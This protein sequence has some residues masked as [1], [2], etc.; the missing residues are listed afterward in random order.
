MAMS[1]VASISVSLYLN[2]Q[3]IKSIKRMRGKAMRRKEIPGESQ[4]IEQ[5]TVTIA[6]AKSPPD[7]IVKIDVT[8]SKP[9]SR[10]WVL[11]EKGWVYHG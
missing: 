5:V 6:D 3:H 9:D 10:G 8:E 7:E 1:F 2:M 11:T 4:Q